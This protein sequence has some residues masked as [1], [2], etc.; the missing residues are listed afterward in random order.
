MVIVVC[1]CLTV[2]NCAAGVWHG[3]SSSAWS[4]AAAAC[5]TWHEGK[6]CAFVLG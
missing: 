6:C 5:E 2:C 3:R 1:G 4:S